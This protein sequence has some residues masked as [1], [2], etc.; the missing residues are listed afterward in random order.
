MQKYKPQKVLN[1]RKKFADFIVDKT[2][3]KVGSKFAWLWVAIESMNKQVIHIDLSFKRTMLIVAERFIVASLINR[4]D[5][6]SVSTADGG[7][8][9][10]QACHFLKLKHHL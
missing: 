10:P 9:Y 4:Y 7:I 3:I 2:Q 6:H 5:T 8:W 1:K